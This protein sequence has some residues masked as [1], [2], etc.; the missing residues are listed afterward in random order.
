VI[1]TNLDELDAVVGKRNG[2]AT[3]VRKRF[4]KFRGMGV[5][6]S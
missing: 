3:L 4:E 1:A 6:E 5:W 2:T